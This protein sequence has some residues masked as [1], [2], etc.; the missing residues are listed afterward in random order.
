M[1]LNKTHKAF[2]ELVRAGLWEVECRLS[3]FGDL[4]FYDIYRYA[5]EQS[6]VGLVAAGLEHLSDVK[7][8]QEVALTFAGTTLQLE[9]RNKDMN[10]F[11]SKLIGKMREAGIY[12][13]LV[14]GQGVAQCYERPLWRASGDIDLLLDDVNYEKAKILLFSISDEIQKEDKNKKHQA[15]KLMGVDVELHGNMPFVI[16]KRVDKG[17]DA[18]MKDLFCCGNIRSWNCNGTQVFLPSPDNDVILVF[19]HF[20]HHFFIEGVGLRQIC[21]W[22]RLLWLYRNELDCCMLGKRIKQMG[23]LSEWQVF[24]SLAVEYLGVPKEAMPLYNPNYKIKGEKVLKRV[25]KDGNFGHNKDL[26]YKMRYKGFYYKI[27]SLIRR[28]SGFMGLIKVFPR[29]S[30]VFFLTYIIGKV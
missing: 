9:Q 2:L 4:D 25:L 14:K 5:E 23:L 17:I 1:M 22:C 29:D 20:L 24:A 11:I 8:T 16:S 19:T 28:L 10:L 3:Q 30:P 15:L 21:D 27:V 26:S 13:L 6:V 12:A 7:I 18:V